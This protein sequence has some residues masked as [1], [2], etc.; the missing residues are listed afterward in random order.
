VPIIVTSLLAW[1]HDALAP[2]YY[3]MAA[4]VSLGGL[5]PWRD[6]AQAPLP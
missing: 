5:L 6:T 1:T 3:L 4:A 2:A